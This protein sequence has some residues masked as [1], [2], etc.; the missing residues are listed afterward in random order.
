MAIFPPYKI[1][2]P[3]PER[4]KGEV[5]QLFNIEEDPFEQNN[6]ADTNPAIVEDLTAR[7]TA[8]RAE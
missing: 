2:I 5:V 6:I 4:K 3:D 7:I 8:F 1:I